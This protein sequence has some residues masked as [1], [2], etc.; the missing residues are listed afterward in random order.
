LESNWRSL[1]LEIG[2]WW[3]G[4]VYG[5]VPRFPLAARYTPNTNWCLTNVVDYSGLYAVVMISAPDTG[6]VDEV[7]LLP[8]V[9]PVVFP[10]GYDVEPDS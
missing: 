4:G 1:A 6:V 9:G 2:V 10:Y 5:A 3:Y 8:I 7:T